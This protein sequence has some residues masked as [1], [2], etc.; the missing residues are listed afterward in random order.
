M[1]VFK[2]DAI[3][4][5]GVLRISAVDP[6]AGSYEDVFSMG[7]IS[8]LELFHPDGI[9]ERVCVIGDNCPTR[10]LPEFHRVAGDR[11]DLI[12]LAPSETELRTERWLQNAMLAVN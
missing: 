12:I 7:R 4:D 11:A 10:L 2:G 8:P 3:E 5:P 6:A 1:F 9:V